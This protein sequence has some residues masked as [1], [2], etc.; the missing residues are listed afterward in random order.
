MSLS[1]RILH[2]VKL[3]LLVFCLI[4][5]AYYTLSPSRNS[6][7]RSLYNVAVSGKKG[8]FIETAS[9]TEIDGPFDNTTLV[10]LCKSRTWTP[11][12][13]FKCESPAGGIA[14]VRNIILNCV[15]YAIEAGGKPDDLLTKIQFS[16]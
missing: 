8:A 5:T 7:Y 3:S 11:G 13:I 10:E 16:S 15:R 12:L 4:F 14:N 9:T 1:P 6:G 2:I